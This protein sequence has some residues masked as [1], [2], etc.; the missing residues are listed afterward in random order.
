MNT[1]SISS[2]SLEP[3]VR[4]LHQLSPSSQ[5]AIVALVKQF[6]QREGVNV[7]SAQSPGLQSPI[8]GVPLWAAKLKAERY[9]ERTTHMYI[10]L[11]TRF[12]GRNPNPTRLEVQAHLAGRLEEVSPALVSNERKALASLFGFLH[13]EGLWPSN[14][15]SGVG[16]VRV[17]Y[18]ERVCP[19][20]EDVLK[21][22]EA[23]CARRKDTD[24]LRLLILLLATTGIRISEAAT[25]LRESIDLKS[26]EIRVRG[27]GDR[28]RAV[29]LLPAT[30]R[31]IE[32]YMG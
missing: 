4:A 9:S 31:A 24:K 21:V 2:N 17:R 32:D 12:L 15:L 26:L 3:T 16:H 5:E 28:W 14:P 22:M 10:Y 18:R 7:P 1:E 19:D 30:A 11:A 23:G 27:K 6:A 13:A 25:L 20:I 8:D 29:P